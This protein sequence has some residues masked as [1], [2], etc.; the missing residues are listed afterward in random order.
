MKRW[1]CGAITRKS[2]L[3]R[4]D[5]MKDIKRCFLGEG[6]NVALGIDR[7]EETHYSDNLPIITVQRSL[8]Y[9]M[10]AIITDDDS[11]SRR[12][13]MTPKQAK[14]VS[15]CLKKLAKRLKKSR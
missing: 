8:D 14:G 15:K 10:L 9:V 7:P 2:Y 11:T 13:L 3:K 5:L 12:I 1:K 6:V 4:G